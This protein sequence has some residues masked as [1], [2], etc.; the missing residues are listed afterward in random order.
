MRCVTPTRKRTIVEAGAFD[1]E[2]MKKR[3]AGPTAPANRAGCVQ[4]L[5]THLP[6][7]LDTVGEAAK[8]DT[9]TETFSD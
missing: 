4:G 7:V 2:R 9:E 3:R 8:V 1:V 6:D 5:F